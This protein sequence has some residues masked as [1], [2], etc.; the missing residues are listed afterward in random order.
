MS[1]RHRR[2]LRGLHLAECVIMPAKRREHCTMRQFNLTLSLAFLAPQ[3]VKA[4]VDI[5]R[6]RPPD[7]EQ[8][9]CC[10]SSRLRG[11]TK[12]TAPTGTRNRSTPKM[13]I[14]EC[15]FG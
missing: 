2:A 13:A 6:L 9:S 14:R 3:P 7:P 15:R 12:R 11:S 8:G 10:E 4:A 1:A 5:E